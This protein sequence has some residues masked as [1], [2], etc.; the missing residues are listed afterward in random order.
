LFIVNNEND[1]NS[2][3][4]KQGFSPDK[5]LIIYSKTIVILYEI[6]YYQKKSEIISKNTLEIID[7]Y[8]FAVYEYFISN[9]NKN[10]Q[11]ILITK[12]IQ[13]CFI[14]INGKNDIFNETFNYQCILNV[15]NND[16]D[17]FEKFIHVNFYFLAWFLP[18]VN[19]FIFKT[20]LGE[21]DIRYKENKINMDENANENKINKFLFYFEDEYNENI[22]K[23]ISKFFALS[24]DCKNTKFNIALKIEQYNN[25]FKLIIR[26]C[27]IE[28]IQIFNKFICNFY[29]SIV[30]YKFKFRS[31]VKMILILIFEIGQVKI[32]N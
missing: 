25:L 29:L 18:D 23:I 6:I 15:F 21:N 9:L 19:K 3:T 10:K 14:F 24:I 28:N 20:E 4:S 30:D 27:L 17:R 13:F 16:Y 32:F 1:K 11:I 5:K 22:Y 26:D 7:F 8:K 12:I 31:L 2:I